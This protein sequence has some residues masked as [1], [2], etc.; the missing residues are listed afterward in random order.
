MH[1]RT[2]SIMLVTVMAVTAVA[3]EEKPENLARKAKITATSECGASH[4]AKFVADGIIPEARMQ[5]SAGKEWAARGNEHPG[6]VELTMSW[7][8]PVDSS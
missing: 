8:A 3:A 1:T 2:L 7:D 6:G 4:L 5:N